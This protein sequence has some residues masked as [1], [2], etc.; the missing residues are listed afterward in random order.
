MVVRLVYLL[1]VLLCLFRIHSL[2]W[3]VDGVVLKKTFGEKLD[4]GGHIGGVVVVGGEQVYPISEG[5]VV[6]IHEEGSREWEL[7]SGLGNFVVVEHPMEIFSIYSGLEVIASDGLP[8]EVGHRDLLGTLPGVGSVMG[9]ELYLEIVDRQFA[10][11]VNPLLALPPLLDT[12]APV[13]EKVII[14]TD[15]PTNI[16]EQPEIPPGSWGIEV[17]TYDPNPDFPYLH[18]KTPIRIEVYANGERIFQ[19]PFEIIGF[20]DGVPH[21]LTAGD[22]HPL[23]EIWGSR[24]GYMLGVYSFRTGEI[25]LR[26]EVSDYSD[27]E[28]VGVFKITV[29]RQE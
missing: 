20:E 17:A 8:L 18:T 19:L 16:N 13:I 21:L 4:G 22:G 3:P 5:R 9:G 6:L 23:E 10:H 25:T 11:L 1:P 24:G 2:E 27:N 26:V 14:A 7:P 29:G 15:P 12:T 28:S